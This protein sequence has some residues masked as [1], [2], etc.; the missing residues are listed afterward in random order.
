MKLAKYLK[1]Y[2][3]CA[4]L[5]PLCMLGEVLIDLLQPKLMSK[6]VNDGVLGNNMHL[7]IST[8]LLMLLLVAVGGIAGA[9]A[10]GFA[11]TASQKFGNDLRKDAFSK[12]MNLSFQQTDKFTTGSLVTRL[13]NDISMTQDFVA[14]AL[15]IFVRAPIT[16]VGGIIMALSLNAKFGIVLICALPVQLLI[17]AILLFKASPMFSIVQKKLD[18]VNSVTQENVNGARTV[19]AFL[20]EDYETKRF[21]V[22][23]DE[24]VNTN[25]KVQKILAL[26]MPLL[27]IIM[28]LSVIAVIYIGGYQTEA[29]EMQ[30]GD[31]MAAVTYI[32]QILMS[33]MMVGMMFQ[34]ISRAKA[35]AARIVEVL[36]TT[37]CIL[38]GSYR[39][40]AASAEIEFKNVSFFYPGHSGS[41]ILNNI[42]FTVKPGEKI[43]ILGS[44]GSGKSSLV[45]LIPRFYDCTDGEVLFN[46]VD[47]KQYDLE[48]LR[49]KI[50][51][52]LQKSELFTGT[53]SDN[54]RWGLPNATDE[55]VV[56][57]AKIAQADDFI[58]SFNDG[59][60]TVIEE[61]GSSL[62]GGQ[63]QR[64]S[65][66]RAIIRHPS[67]IIFDDSA[68]A[69][70]LGTES[71]LQKALAENLGDIT[72]ITIAQR[73]ASIMNSDRIL[74]LE[75]GSIVADGSHEELLKTS[76]VYA[77]IYDSQTKNANS[78]KGADING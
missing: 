33:L 43:A 6:I 2:W 35:S 7:I 12:V 11:G 8:G 10:S 21:N 19:K 5:S 69:L 29:R 71:R 20:R 39:D 15:R 68:S 50:G 77:D 59:Y 74:V 27:M 9:A 26:I 63:K 30:A 47:V 75:N 72:T 49:S 36:N 58:T 78:Q 53:I 45:N 14:Q 41:P 34:S 62:S 44:T 37:P 16:F 18:K 61:K 17:L 66:A 54:I 52:A 46:G 55:E 76:K 40:D 1:P 24:L 25:I 67:L 23:N 13:T 4:I 42:S 3:L 48:N 31:V 38:S 28:N 70:D 73:I 56:N 65:I 22:A 60:D 57:A 32:T 51:F 64:I